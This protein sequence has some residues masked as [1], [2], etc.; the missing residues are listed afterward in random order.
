MEKQHRMLIWFRY[1]HL[2]KKFQVISKP[3]HDLAVELDNSLKNGNEKTVAFRK[4]LE[5]KD[6]AVRAAVCPGQ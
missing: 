3:F 6:A 5:A 4:L 1:N 2:P